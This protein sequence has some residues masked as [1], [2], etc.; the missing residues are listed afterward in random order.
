MT[1]KIIELKCVECVKLVDNQYIADFYSVDNERYQIA[2]HEEISVNTIIR[3]NTYY[4]TIQK[5]DDYF[6][7]SIK[8]NFV[9]FSTE[10]E[11]FEFFLADKYEN[12]D[13]LIS[14]YKDSNT[15][16]T[17]KIFEKGNKDKLNSTRLINLKKEKWV[18]V[19]EAHIFNGNYIIENWI[20]VLPQ[21][22]KK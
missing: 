12:N 21:L 16:E 19:K 22:P 8:Q 7:V 17:F 10:P 4:H 15:L 5:I 14:V 2:F 9:S 1:N 13:K 3:I 6:R 11:I 20:H 18:I